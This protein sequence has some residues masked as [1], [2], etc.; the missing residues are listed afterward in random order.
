MILYLAGPMSGHRHFNFP[1][2]ERCAY[3]L[4]RRGFEVISPHEEDDPEVQAAA[5]RSETGDFADLPDGKVGSDLRA[6]VVANTMD[7]T[8]S[9]GLALLPGWSKSNGARHEVEIAT[10]LHLP[11]A[12]VEV[13]MAVDVA[14]IEATYDSAPQDRFQM[15]IFE[16]EA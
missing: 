2:F 11:V 10:R 4:R 6:T 13:W 14:A 3:E 12:P 1:A 16:V 7:V 15:T 9:Q 8:R 5:W